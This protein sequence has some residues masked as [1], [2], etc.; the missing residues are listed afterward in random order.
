MYQSMIFF[1][2][3]DDPDIQTYTL[4]AIGSICIRH[5]EFMLEVDL[6][7]FYHKLLT[8]DDAPLQMKVEVLHNIEMYLVEEE[9]RMIQQDLECE[10]RDYYS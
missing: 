7:N 1:L 8:N 2:Q 6:K 9:N 5:Y 3:R 4:K 10:L